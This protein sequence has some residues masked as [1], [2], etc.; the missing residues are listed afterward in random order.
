MAELTQELFK[1]YQNYK[2]Q[3]S[4]LRIPIFGKSLL[5]SKRSTF[6]KGKDENEWNRLADWFDTYK[7][8]DPRVRWLIQIPHIY[9]VR[10]QIF[11][12][13]AL[14]SFV[15]FTQREKN[16]MFPANLG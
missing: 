8:Y 9:E 11:I 7:L 5:L 10:Y 15:E 13:N 6:I 14:F 2:F 3:V 1:E 16:T 12:I 4:E